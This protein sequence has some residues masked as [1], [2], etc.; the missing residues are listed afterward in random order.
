M[1]QRR[2]RSRTLPQVLTASLQQSSLLPVEHM[3]RAAAT[4]RSE[5]SAAEQVASAAKYWNGQGRMV[6]TS[7]SAVYAETD[8]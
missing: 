1:L 3:M 6:F 4:E 2:A 5:R 8:G 7:S